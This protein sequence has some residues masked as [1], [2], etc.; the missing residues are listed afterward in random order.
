MGAR[1]TALT[2]LIACRKQGAWA[3]GI[4]KEY[5]IRDQLDRREA[6]LAVRL[7]YG[8]LQ[9]RMLIDH[10]LSQLL[11]FSI[12]KLQ[13][14]VLDILRLGIYQLLFMDRIPASAAVNE[15]VKLGK[16]YGGP[17]AAGLIN[18]VLRRAEREKD[19][20]SEPIDLCTKY[21]HPQELVQ[22]LRES[23]PETQ[24][25]TL[26]R[27]NNEIP[28]TIIQVNRLCSTSSDLIAELNN[29]GIICTEH[30]WL[31]YACVISNFGNLEHLQAFKNGKFFVQDSAAALAVRAA[32]IRPGMYVL[33]GCSAPGGKSFYAS[34]EMNNTGHVVSCDIHPHKIE[35]LKSGADRLHISVMEPC[36][37]DATE[38]VQEWMGIMDV[39]IAD[40]PCSGLGIIRKKP[41]IRY[42]TEEDISFLPVLQRKILQNLS[43]YVK[44][45][46]TLLYSTCT[47]LKRENEDVISWFLD[48]H[49]QFCLEEF[50]L[51]IPSLPE[52]CSM[53]TLF[54][55]IHGT[56]GFFICKMR[57]AK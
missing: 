7:T 8:V 50:S 54:P 43:L 3:D 31:P 15:A 25:D 52:P 2:A 23:I 22:L 48:T 53:V 28:E 21:S 56:D 32:D 33:D 9:N 12:K 49:P 5:I 35:L 55:N 44:P 37:Q 29:S 6:A 51:P 47:I 38:P 36:L 10:Y 45:G 16:R 26:L 46:G 17:K 13:P 42:K 19:K 14:T 24:I 18:G 40:V 4:L 30:A 11:N 20:L 41:D 1:I 39:V 57:R 34:I 27:A